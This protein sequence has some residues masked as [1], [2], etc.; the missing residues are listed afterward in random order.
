MAEAIEAEVRQWI[1]SH[2]H[3]ADAAGR[4]VVRNGYL[5]KRSILTGIGP[6]EVQANDLAGFIA[7]GAEGEVF[8]SKILPPYGSDS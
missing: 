4:Q 3:F 1:D 7:A 8:S 2:A 6:V 5:S